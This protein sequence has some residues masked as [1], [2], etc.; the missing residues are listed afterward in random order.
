MKESRAPI[1]LGKK[2]QCGAKD[3]MKAMS[4]EWLPFGLQ[5]ELLR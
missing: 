3:R 1:K 5:E 4:E 2:F